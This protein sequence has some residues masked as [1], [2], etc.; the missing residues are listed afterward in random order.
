MPEVTENVA[1]RKPCGTV[2][3]VGT[4]AAAALELESDMTAPPATAGAIRVTVP[5]A[6]WPLTRVAGLTE[7]LLRTT[8]GGLTAMTKAVLAP[9]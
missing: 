8:E 5:V 4:L 3:V 2:T 1:E 7:I 6:D 9:E